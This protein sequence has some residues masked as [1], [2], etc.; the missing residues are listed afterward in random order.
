V[1]EIRPERATKGRPLKSNV[2]PKRRRDQR[3]SPSRLNQHL[4]ITGHL[5]NQTEVAL[6]EIEMAFLDFLPT[7]TYDILWNCAV[8]LLVRLYTKTRI[9]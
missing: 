2:I 8:C 3:D 5:L 9:F 4:Q 6:I 7:S 1:S